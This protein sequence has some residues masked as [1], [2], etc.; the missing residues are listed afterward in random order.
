[1]AE[2]ATL[3]YRLAD[4]A[5][6][7]T[8]ADV[9]A[10]QV[11]YLTRLLADTL[12]CALAARS[13]TVLRLASYA[14]RHRSA[15][16]PHATLLAT[17][18][19]GTTTATRT[20]VA[21]AALANTAAARDLD[22]NDL[23]LSS[24]STDA[25]HFSNAIPAILSAAEAEGASG[26]EMLAATLAVYETQA[27]LGDVANWSAQGW[28]TAGL[29]AWALPASVARL[30]G[31][32]VEQG[33]TAS[34]LAGTLGQA[35]PSWLRPGKP[36]TAMKTLAPGMIAQRAVEAVE[37]ARLG[38]TAPDD[39]LDRTLAHLGADA[40]GLPWRRLGH[41]WTITRNLI[42][43]YPAQYL[44]QAAIQAAL[45]LYGRGVR[46]E[47]VREVRVVGHAGVCGGIQ[48]SPRAFAPESREDADHS[49]PF[50]VATAL[51]RGRLTPDEYDGAPWIE[52]DL[53]DLMGHIKLIMEPER[54]RARR[55]EGVIGCSVESELRDGHV[56]AADVRQPL[57]HPEA[58]MPDDEL[59]RKMRELLGD[60][61]DANLPGRLLAAC[62]ALPAAPNLDA[63]L[64]V[65]R[66]AT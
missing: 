14:A 22:A 51:L 15:E 17:Q 40:S 41:E 34:A 54:E 27:V 59:L 65:L 53:R 48:G 32:T 19:G 30:R 60:R 12:A 1:M 23:Y 6:H 25:A 11:R 61:Y 18:G 36:V 46:A 47:S 4:F 64:G 62:D 44:T 58:P 63:L 42:K 3:T 2:T 66:A 52:P 16:G 49:T 55:E 10:E 56:E 20:D 31:L 39:A 9:P 8:L 28:N 7:V 35:F 57:G 26:P 38:M 13:Y 37:F 21:L 50:V 29:V 45:E 5:R 24:M 33:A 43:R